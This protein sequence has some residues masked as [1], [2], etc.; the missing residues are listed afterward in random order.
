MIHVFGDS[1]SIDK[2]N[3]SWVTR[4]NATSY[5]TRGASQYRIWKT[6][7]LNKHLIEQDD[8]ILFCH[9]SPYRIFLKTNSTLLSRLLP[10]HLVCDIIIN[11]IIAKK[12][13]KFISILNTI[14][15]EDYF[16]DTYLLLVNDLMK[17]P[18]S[19]H[20]TFFESDLIHSF[21]KTWKNNAGSINHLS[22]NGNNDV[23]KDISKWLD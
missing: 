23:Y 11:D 22:V 9:T 6:Y 1:F 16:Y 5:S 2:S 17:V 14:W 12:E 7:Q 18:N 3:D 13:L 10:S 20:F 4:L 15:D 21:Y 8:I 19:F